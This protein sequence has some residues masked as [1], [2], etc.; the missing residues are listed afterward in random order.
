MVA[1]G[2]RGYNGLERV[3]KAYRE[4]QGVTRAYRGL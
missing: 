1:R 2:Y 4:L 3:I